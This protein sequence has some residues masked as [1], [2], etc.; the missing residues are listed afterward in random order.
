MRN[1]VFVFCL[2]TCVCSRVKFFFLSLPQKLFVQNVF[3]CFF[4]MQ[5]CSFYNTFFFSFF[6]H[7]KKILE[8]KTFILRGN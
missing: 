6:G 3:F 1:F 4:P 7:E 5:N 2:H 8:E